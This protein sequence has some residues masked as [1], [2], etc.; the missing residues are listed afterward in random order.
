MNIMW[1]TLFH[2]ENIHLFRTYQLFSLITTPRFVYLLVYL[3]KSLSKGIRSLGSSVSSFST[4][5]HNQLLTDSTAQC[6]AHNP[7]G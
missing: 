5:S 7:L 2:P 1:L 4:Q 3:L 6:G